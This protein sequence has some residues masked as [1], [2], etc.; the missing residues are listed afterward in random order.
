MLSKVTRVTEHGAVE[1]AMPPREAGARSGCAKRVR[2]VSD[3]GLGVG[4][5]A[6]SG[7]APSAVAA[8]TASTSPV[9]LSKEVW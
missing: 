8:A 7:W 6:R 9:P 2:G 1:Q 3:Y 4:V 5:V